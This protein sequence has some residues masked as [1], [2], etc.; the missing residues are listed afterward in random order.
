MTSYLEKIL[1]Q[2]GD[3][4]NI[5]QYAGYPITQF[6]QNEDVILGGQTNVGISRL[7]GLTIPV[8]LYSYK[9]KA[10][11]Q[12]DDKPSIEMEITVIEEPIYQKLLDN[13]GDT[14]SKKRTKRNKTTKKRKP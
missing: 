6:I 13:I 2:T 10:I 7:D 9:E 8:G 3:D 12:C 11:Q 5:I 1:Y 4:G 14:N